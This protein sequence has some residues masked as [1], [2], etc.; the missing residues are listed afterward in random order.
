[1]AKKHTPYSD[2]IEQYTDTQFV[3]Y[4]ESLE[5]QAQQARDDGVFKV[6]EILDIDEVHSDESLVEAIRYF[7]KNAGQIKDDAPVNFLTEREKNSLNQK[8]EFRSGLYCMLLSIK[9]SEAMQNKSLFFEHS[10][11]YAFDEQKVQY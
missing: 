8:R 11:N 1:M 9:Y 10:L 4:C 7:K 3:R 2:A 5:M 6:M